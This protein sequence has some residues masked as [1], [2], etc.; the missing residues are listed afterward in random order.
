MTIPDTSK[1]LLWF[2]GLSGAGKTTIAEAVLA[3]LVRCGERAELLDGD[4]IRAALS[5]DLGFSRRDRDL[6]V[7]RL[8][9]VASL[10]TRNGITVLVSAISPFSGPR[11]AAIAK[12]SLGHEIYVKA[13]LEVVQTRDTKG[14]YA[15]ARR[16][17][18]TGLTGVDDPYEEPL[19]PDLVL[20][21][22]RSELQSCV[23][24]ALGLIGKEASFARQ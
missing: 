18:I 15:R 21:T 11:R 13:A 12:S 8:G 19:Q 22:G 20:D 16:G 4:E 6:Q 10:L 7:A 1:P 9:F 2:T 14:L 24:A 5:P 23:R 3:E 17:E